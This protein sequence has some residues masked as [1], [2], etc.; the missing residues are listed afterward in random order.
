MGLMFKGPTTS[1]PVAV[2]ANMA[3]LSKLG[4]GVS[5]HSTEVELNPRGVTLGAQATLP[6]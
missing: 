1:S 5:W 4:L 2:V 3:L 6:R